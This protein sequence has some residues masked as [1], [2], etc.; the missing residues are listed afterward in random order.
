MIWNAKLSRWWAYRL[1]FKLSNR[2]VRQM[3]PF[4]LVGCNR[5]SVSIASVDQFR[6]YFLISFFLFYL[7]IFLFFVI[8][9]AVLLQ[10]N[11]YS[12]L[13]HDLCFIREKYWVIVDNWLLHS[14]ILVIVVV[15]LNCSQTSR[16]TVSLCVNRS[17]N[18]V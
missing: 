13:I 3:V 12:T 1:L 16:T 6:Q 2:T 7:F 5:L 8:P 15:Q 9:T 14:S 10:D 17:L 4:L 18:S 11:I